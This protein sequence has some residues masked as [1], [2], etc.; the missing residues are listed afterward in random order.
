MPTSPYFAADG[1]PLAGTTTVINRWKESGGLLFWAHGI[2]YQQGLNRE[3]SQLYAKRDEAADIGTHTH[4]LIEADIKNMP[5]PAVPS[6]LSKEDAA[7]AANAFEQ[8]KAWEKQNGLFVVA[9]ERP[10]V[11]ER[12]RFGGTPDA[13]AELDGLI[14]LLDW[15]TSS[16]VYPD[17]LLQ[18]AAYGMLLEE[19]RPDM[20][21]ASRVH[22]LRFSK[23]WKDFEHRSF[24][25]LEVERRQFLRL[26]EAYKDDSIIRKRI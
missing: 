14:Y 23:D 6:N 18:L 15:K 13:L 10:L 16:G 20:K 22:V 8:F 11:S 5:P 21:L 2:G 19:N 25:G 1:T 7:R 26:L 4:A 3:R 17:N 12:Y 9:W 24:D